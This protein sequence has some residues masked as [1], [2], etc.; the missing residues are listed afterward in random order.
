M[1]PGETERPCWFRSRASRSSALAQVSRAGAALSDASRH[2]GQHVCCHRDRGEVSPVR[3]GGSQ[4]RPC[5]HIGHRRPPTCD[6][7]PKHGASCRLQPAP[8]RG[9]GVGRMGNGPQVRACPNGMTSF[10]DSGGPAG[11][12]PESAVHPIPAHG[13]TPG[14]SIA[15][16]VG[17]KSPPCP[18]HLLGGAPS[19]RMFIS[20]GPRKLFSGSTRASDSRCRRGRPAPKTRVGRWIING[21]FGASRSQLRNEPDSS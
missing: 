3:A 21:K 17:V 1:Q 8:N 13:G 19:G 14:R 4:G 12:Y 16:W 5:R 2:G 7:P 11:G 10:D 18:G 20:A 9:V 6:D 15:S